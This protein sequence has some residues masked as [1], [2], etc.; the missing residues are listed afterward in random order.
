MNNHIYVEIH[1]LHW[2][3]FGQN[4]LRYAIFKLKFNHKECAKS[5]VVYIYIYTCTKILLNIEATLKKYQL[6]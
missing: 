4:G 6:E 2:M 3:H 1:Q 5:Q